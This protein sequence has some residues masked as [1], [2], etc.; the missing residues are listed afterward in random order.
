MIFRVLTLVSLTVFLFACGSNS[1]SIPG[2]SDLN[3]EITEIKGR[4]M[5]LSLIAGT[6]DEAVSNEFSDCSMTNSVIKRMCEVAQS[7][8]AQGNVE[9]LG[10]MANFV[11]LLN[12]EIDAA[13]NDL[14][15]HQAR[16]NQLEVDSASYAADIASIQADLSTLNASLLTMQADIAA[17]DSRLDTAE[18][19]IDAL[20]DALDDLTDS[21]NSNLPELLKL[22]A[23]GK[24]N[25]SAGPL[26]ESL[27]RKANKTE[28]T[29]YVN[30]YNAPVSLA[31]NAVD[32][33]NG[34]PTVT[35]TSSANH[36][37]SVGNTVL[38][39]NVGEGAGF[40]S[41]DLYGEFVVLTVPTATTFT[42]NLPR[43]A[44]SG[45]TFG[46]NIGVIQKVTARG[47][48]LIWK[49]GDA[50]DSAVRQTSAGSQKYNFIIR[51]IASDVT[52]NTAEVC[53]SKSSRTATFATINAA[54]EGGNASI[55]C[56]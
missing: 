15:S 28:I 36:G 17:L 10:Q 39:M 44:T 53:W 43:N 14:A 5:A 27:I 1:V 31:N 8:V 55:T 20:Q 9:V 45:N 41:G 3:K 22:I 25:L 30:A 51:R 16:L 48:G 18:N 7:A 29:G 24:E 34:S 19:D 38:M 56:Q 23:I 49:S 40:T 6:L 13:N 11:N 4:I 21:F 50:S 33:T 26:Y 54:P 2:G 32:P 12:G 42:I 35:V 52:N 37:L 47:F 46:G